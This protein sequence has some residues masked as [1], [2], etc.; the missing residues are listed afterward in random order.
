MLKHK[1]IHIIYLFILCLGI[2]QKINS[3]NITATPSVGCAPLV[4]VQFSGLTGGTNIQWSFGDGTFSNL[5][6]PTHTYS[7][8]G[9][10]VATYTA[11]VSG[12]ST[13]KTI[14]IV[15]HGKP[16]P[17]FTVNITKGCVPLSVSFTDQ[18]VNTGGTL[19]PQW[20]W[21]FGDGG[22]SSLQN[23][24][25]VYTIPGT[26]N[27][28]LIYKDGHGCD[29]S[30]TKTALI[31][32]SIKPTVVITSSPTVINACS[33]PFTATF[34]G[35]GSGSNS[36]TGSTSLTYSWNLNG[37]SS[38]SVNPPPITFTTTGSFPIS[39]TATDNNSCSDSK[40]VTVNVS[41]PIQSL[42]HLSKTSHV[43]IEVLLL[44]TLL[45]QTLLNGILEM[46]LLFSIFFPQAPLVILILVQGFL[47]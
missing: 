32:T 26:F 3:Q 11:V 46:G 19:P 34:S 20:Q 37:S 17:N 36:T 9:N 14:S 12:V 6:N 39:L 42:K 5:N 13:T 29:S 15:A 8:P 28:T 23:P 41:N 21:S 43:L 27:V 40:T 38:T 2:T 4:G 16:T 22:V 31:K 45:Y 7:S 35:S 18:S 47:L 25:Y 44:E 33:A 30:I 24:N 1:F 10:F